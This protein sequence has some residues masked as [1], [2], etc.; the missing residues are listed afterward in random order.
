MSGRPQSG[1]ELALYGS[2]DGDRTEAKLRL[3]LLMLGLGEE[4]LDQAR[5]EDADDGQQEGERRAGCS[6]A[7]SRRS[8]LDEVL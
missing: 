4:L 7:A 1:R 6:R 2:G 5:E 3:L 8:P